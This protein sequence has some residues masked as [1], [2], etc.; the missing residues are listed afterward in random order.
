MP[1]SD[2]QLPP[3][4]SPAAIDANRRGVALRALG[5]L[6]EAAGAFREGIAAQPELALLHANLA[7]LLAETGDVQAAQHEYDLAL[8]CEPDLSAALSGLG[9][10][11]VRMGRFE[12]AR[13]CYER[14]LA[15]EP[16]DMGAH[17][18]MYE[19]EQI[20]GNAPKAL[21]HQREILARKTLF[22]HYAPNEQRRLLAL[23]APGDWQAN[24]P[25]DFLIDPLTT[26]LHKLY[27]IS[28]EQV[29]AASIPPAD[30]VFTAIAESDE[31][32]QALTMAQQLLPR[33]GL[34]ALNDPRAILAANRVNVARELARVPHLHAPATA[35]M[36]RDAL[37]RAAGRLDYPVLI[38][39]VGSQAGRDLARVNGAAE[40]AAY[41]H[42]VSATQFYVTPFIDYRKAD[43]YYR[44]YR[45][46]IVDG[47]PYPL[48]LAIS[49]NWMIHYYNAPMRETAW[50]REEEAFF[51]AHFEQVFEEPL[52]QAL[53]AIP[54]ILGLDYVGVD[55]S[56]DPQGR[57]LVFEADPAMVVH[58]G[59]DPQIFPYKKPYAQRIFDAFQRLVDRARS[60]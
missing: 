36:L 5:R 34:P 33:I 12:E 37:E 25:I 32:V 24:V 60:R 43:G 46:I 42:G 53:R 7:T 31:S 11:H 40:T 55:C 47:V 1:I 54:R 52:Q 56:I 58:A 9:A 35:H 29:A 22:S 2:A 20:G 44:K 48:H 30:V 16:N 38:R 18:A 50:M 4:P 3:R 17:Q 27:L 45:I 21:A 19:I 26:T 59:D 57:L 14:V 15:R 41:L 13:A 51:L 6:E 23:F 10:L 8:K 28:P 49:P 39:P